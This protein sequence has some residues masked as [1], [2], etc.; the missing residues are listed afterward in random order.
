[1]INIGN[2]KVDV[3]YGDLT[4]S[5][6]DALVCP[7]NNYLWMGGGE[8][9]AIK[10][11]GGQE[12]ENE[13]VSLGPVE[14]G[15]SVITNAGKLPCRH[16]IHTVISDQDLHTDETI[17][18]HSIQSTLIIAEK[19]KVKSI[20]FP[21]IGLHAGIEPHLCARLMFDE[22]MKHLVNTEVI[23][24]VIIVLDDRETEKLFHDT[25]IGKFTR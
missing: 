3:T 8:A 17:V 20:A 7:T 5:M 21:G 14:K 22:I 11:A 15:T 25:L 18:R 16:V 10:K 9:S 4:K 1:M 23:E 24:T 13:A 12:I 19:N 6:V 2:A